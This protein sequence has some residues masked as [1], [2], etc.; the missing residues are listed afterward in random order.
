MDASNS[1]TSA[2]NNT[3][4]NDFTSWAGWIGAGTTQRGGTAATGAAAR[5]ALIKARVKCRD[6][7]L[8]GRSFPGE[9]F[10]RLDPDGAGRVSR[11]AFKQALREMGFALVDESPPDKESGGRPK[12][13]EWENLTQHR[14]QVSTAMISSY[15][16]MGGSIP[17]HRQLSDEVG[18]GGS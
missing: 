13:L 17:S 6:A 1:N 18:S 16:Q 3:N 2:N 12:G 15:W 4:N 8:L 11:L 9:A 7:G 14:Q 5:R 10:V